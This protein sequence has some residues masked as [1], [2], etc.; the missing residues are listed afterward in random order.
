V[1]AGGASLGRVRLRIRYCAAP[2][3]RV[4]YCTSGGGPA[5]LLDSGWVSHLLG[6]LELFSFSDFVGRL[7]ERFTVIRYDKPGCGLSDRDGA[8]L[9]FDG[10]VAAALAVADAVGAGRFCLFGASQ[11]G[12]V[13]A[14][15][16]ARYPERVQALVVYGMCASGRDLAPAEVRASV[17]GLVRAHWGLGLKALTGAFVTDPSAEEVAAFTRAQRA[18]ASAKVAA[19][20]LE[21]YYD[22]DITALLPAIGARTAVLHREADRGTRFELGREVAALIPGAELIP[23]PGSSH[24]FYHGDWP[25]VAEATL[26]FLCEPVSAGPRL[27]GRELQVADLVAEGLTNQAIATRLSVAPRTAE[28][29]VENIRRKLRVRSRAQIAAWATENRLRG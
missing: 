3:G 7:A 1:L 26:G 14:A 22:T 28:A 5:L 8:D 27:T 19:R 6:Q 13:A 9:S 23:L 29:H 24:L 25:A 20:L 16:A 10:Q 21:V 18:S 2:S 17:V 12:Q 4:A 15:I 11:G